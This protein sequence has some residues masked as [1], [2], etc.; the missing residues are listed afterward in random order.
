MRKGQR[1]GQE[2][3]GQKHPPSYASCV[4]ASVKIM[5]LS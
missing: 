4:Q 3:Q 2:Q 1:Q 5:G